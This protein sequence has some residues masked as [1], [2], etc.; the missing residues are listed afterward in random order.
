MDLDRRAFLAA[1]A[2]AG[3]GA[4]L[5]ASAASLLPKNPSLPD[6]FLGRS[7]VFDSFGALEMGVLSDGG[8]GVLPGR[9]LTAVH[10]S[11]ASRSFDVAL[12]A[13]AAWGR[14]FHRQ[15]QQ[16]VSILTAE[17]IERSSNQGKLGILLGL[18]NATC[19]DDNVDNLYTLH[20]AGARVIQL[21]SESRNLLGNGC[22]EASNAGLSDFGVAAVETMNELGMVVDL[23]LCG[24]ET[25]R[26]GIQ[27]SR[28]PPAF[29]HTSCRALH[30]HQR[31]KS[32]ELLRAMAERGGMIGIHPGDDRSSEEH[33]DHITHAVKVAGIDH[34][35]IASS[36]GDWSPRSR[37]SFLTVARGLEKRVYR[38]EGIE[39][40]LGGNWNRYLRQAL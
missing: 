3:A 8:R 15:P 28:K 36:S 33:L 7:L 14:R 37:V 32:D 35:G 39:K 9:G 5:P 19:I 23:S 38:S 16:L 34:V 18:Q 11:L 29:T 17:D 25:S 21:T 26:D 6:S 22:N 27:I 40:L 12:R 30:D 20:A 10:T 24:E 2:A 13:L 4:A 31:A 1:L